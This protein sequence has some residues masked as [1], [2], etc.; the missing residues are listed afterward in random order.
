MIVLSSHEMKIAINTRL[1]LKNQLEGIGWYS[2]ETLRRM[3]IRH[4]EHEFIF[5]FDRQYS[6]DYIFA[7]N[8]T[9]I[10]IGPPTR[11]PILW[12]YWFEV[13]IPKVLKKI[14]ADVFLSLDGFISL[15][16]KVPSISVI[17]DL[18]F[19]HNPERLDWSHSL[20]YRTFFKRYALH[21]KRIVTVS[22]YSKQDIS[23][24]YQVDVDKIDV[25]HNGVN[26]YFKPIEDNEKL[27]VRK[28]Y[29]ENNPYLLILGA[30]NPRKNISNQIIAFNNYKIKSKSTHKLLIVGKKMKWDITSQNILDGLECKNHVIFTGH[31]NKEEIRKVYGAASC[32]LFASHF[33]G[34][35]IPIIEAQ[36][37]GCPV[38]TS[39]CTSMPEV[40]G[41]AAILVDP[42]NTFDIETAIK[43]IIENP[44]LRT[45][46]I[47][48]GFNNSLKFNWDNTAEILW[49]SIKKVLN[50]C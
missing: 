36:K 47:K 30:I 2:F 29:T 26:N 7:H 48:K 23:S 12:Y 13:Q 44:L 34:F 28:K 10:Q 18:N 9:A 5:I 17:H 40:S 22:N 1:L 21:S 20:F 50:K 33:E 4:P 42:N 38:I 43:S 8:V 3:T 49:S 39:N 46:L 32:L 11:H 14:Q 27:E 31:L 35:G 16:S 24:T 19:E 15:S 37:C 25:S 45:E 41:D 6:S